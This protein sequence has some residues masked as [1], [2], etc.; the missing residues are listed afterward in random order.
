[1][2]DRFPITAAG[3]KRLQEELKHLQSVER[4]RIAA[5]IEVARAHGDLRENAEYHAAKEKQA[6]IEGR[7]MDLNGWIA[8][9]EVIDVSKFKGQDTVL[10]GATVELMDVENEK[11]VSYRIVGEFEADLKK[12]WISVNSP[13]ARGLIGKKVGDVAMVTSPGGQREFEILSVDFE[14]VA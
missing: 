1:M 10:F 8:N 7:I 14:D 12:R 5:E 11:K 13:V 9:A 2:S 4:P 6:H 3:L